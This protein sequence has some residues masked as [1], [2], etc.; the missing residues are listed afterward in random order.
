MVI[1][2]IV[3]RHMKRTSNGSF[4]VF[5]GV[6]ELPVQLRLGSDEV[7]IGWYRNPPPWERTIILFTSQAIYCVEQG[8]VERIPIVEIV[9]YESPNSKATTT[10][11]RVLTREGFRFVRLAGSFGPHGNRKDVF[12]FIMVLR[13]LVPDAPIV[14]YP[15]EL[16]REG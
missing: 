2:S 14:H 3:R 5:D 13:A 7:I 1:T 12:S 16:E 10:G 6:T 11:V 8:R 4:T 15:E 9:G